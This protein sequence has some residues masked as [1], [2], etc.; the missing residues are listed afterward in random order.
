M[1][2]AEEAPGKAEKGGENDISGG[3][4]KERGIPCIGRDPLW[5][6]LFL[7][8]IGVFVYL[9]VDA[10][11]NGDYKRMVNQPDFMGPL[12]LAKPACR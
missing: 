12:P 6:A 5:C 7:V 4:V 2:T 3:P 8:H 9:G 10:Q 11:A 1:S